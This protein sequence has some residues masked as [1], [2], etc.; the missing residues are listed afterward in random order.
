MVF[1]WSASPRLFMNLPTPYELT[2][3]HKIGH[4][5]ANNGL[6]LKILRESLGGN[7]IGKALVIVSGL[8]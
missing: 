3:F 5:S 1:V 2:S 7:P 8:L 4:I 6:I